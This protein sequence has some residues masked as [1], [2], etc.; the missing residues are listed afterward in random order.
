MPCLMQRARILLGLATFAA[1]GCD[2][3]TGPSP[4]QGVW[5]PQPGATVALDS[6]TVE[7]TAVSFRLLDEPFIATGQVT[8]GEM[9]GT[10]QA[11]TPFCQCTEPF[12]SETWTARRVDATSAGGRL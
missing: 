8:V 11:A 4:A 6:I 9:S 12:M 2:G 5:E 3:G 1:G 7:G 10:V